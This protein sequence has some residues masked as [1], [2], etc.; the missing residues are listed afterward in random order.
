MLNSRAVFFFL[1]LVSGAVVNAAMSPA[2]VAAAKARANATVAR[3]SKWAAMQNHAPRP[4]APHGPASRLAAEKYLA[5]EGLARHK[6]GARPKPYDKA[7]KA[8]EMQ[9]LAGRKAA[10]KAAMAAMVQASKS[11]HAFGANPHKK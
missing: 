7:A 10:N 2:E 11:A 6:P 1:A 8:L 3:L 5:A 9:K 4:A